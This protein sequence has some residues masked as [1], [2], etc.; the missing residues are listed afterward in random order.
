MFLC[1]PNSPP[2]QAQPL[3]GLTDLTVSLS[4]MILVTDRREGS[5]LL[6][7]VSAGEQIWGSLSLLSSS[8]RLPR[9]YEPREGRRCR[10]RED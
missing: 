1:A 9:T 2:T 6:A 10:A 3:R 5:T 4:W 7:H 8:A